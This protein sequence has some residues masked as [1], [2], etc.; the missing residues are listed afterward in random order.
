VQRMANDKIST[1]RISGDE[2]QVVLITGASSGIGRSCATYLAEKGYKVYGTTRNRQGFE[3]SNSK[4]PFNSIFMDVN[5]IESVN[6]A[7]EKILASEQR[8]DAVIN[9]AGF[10]IGGPV[11]FTS[12]EE[13]QAQFDTNLFGIM[14]VCSAVL[15]AMRSQGA[16]Y[17]INISSLGGLIGLPFQGLYSATKFAV[18]G[19]SEA[20]YGELRS[21]GIRVVLIEPGDFATAFTKNRKQIA[22]PLTDTNYATDFQRTLSVIESDE[23]N[24]ANPIKIAQLIDKILRTPN[25]R[26][27]YRV[28]SFSQ[29]LSV[30]LKKIIPDRLFAWIIMDHY[31]V[32]KSDH[33]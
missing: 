21:Q 8:L 12:I 10:G 27:R 13:A 26:L 9:N 3:D 18:E 20:L 14:R 6:S 28:G 16:G 29:K 23:M 7:I 11:E 17:I 33:K 15:P 2:Q 24:G 5:D 1:S 30:V 32:G 22:K 19:L 31:Q 25:P 4:L